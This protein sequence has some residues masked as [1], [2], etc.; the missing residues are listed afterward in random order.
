[1]K[2]K[3]S[4]LNKKEVFRDF[5][6]WQDL[7]RILSTSDLPNKSIVSAKIKEALKCAR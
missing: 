1:L 6:T 3:H 2:V 7:L 5:V 4:P